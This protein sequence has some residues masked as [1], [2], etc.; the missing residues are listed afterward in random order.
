MSIFAA[1]Q[2]YGSIVRLGPNELSVNCVDNGIKTIYGG[3]F[4]KSHWYTNLF[5][6]YGYILRFISQL[7]LAA[8]RQQRA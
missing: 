3:G 2:K 7:V 1:H 4:E 5:L 8:D 6:N